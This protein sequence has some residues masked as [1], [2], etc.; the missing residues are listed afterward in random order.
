MLNYLQGGQHVHVWEGPVS[1]FKLILAALSFEEFIFHPKGRLVFHQVAS[2]DHSVRDNR[3]EDLTEFHKDVLGGIEG[4]FLEVLAD[5]N[6]DGG[7]VPV[8]GDVLAHQ[9][10]LE[11]GK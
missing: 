4:H 10:R 1:S 8:F 7:F 5:Q 11:G 9:V 2:L 3:A 6:L